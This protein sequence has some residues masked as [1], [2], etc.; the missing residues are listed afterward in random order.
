MTGKLFFSAIAKF[1]LGASLVFVLIF[2]PAGSLAFFNGW[3]LLAILLVPMFF[4]GV[5]IKKVKYRLIPFVW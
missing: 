1:L 3:L 4:A 2:L 5:V